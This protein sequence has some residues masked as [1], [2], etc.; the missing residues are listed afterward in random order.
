[1]TLILWAHALEVTPSQPLHL[2]SKEKKN[3]GPS[4]ALAVKTISLLALLV[5]SAGNVP[6]SPHTFALLKS[7]PTLGL[8]WDL[9]LR[10]SW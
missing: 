4:S 3:M 7:R 6:S 10:H 8:A 5:L 1:M 2:P 9:G